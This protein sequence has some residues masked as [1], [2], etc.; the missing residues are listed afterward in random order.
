MDELATRTVPWA[1]IDVVHA[2][3]RPHDERPPLPAVGDQVWLR[4]VDWEQDPTTGHPV[5]VEL[6]TVVSVQDLEDQDDP[7]LW[8]KISDAHGLPIMAAD[9]TRLR[10]PRADPWPHLD[11][12]RP[13]RFKTDG[14]LAGYGHVIT[15]QESRMRGSA[16]WLPLN[17]RDRPERWRL[18]AETAA[19]TRP[20]L[21]PYTDYL[22]G[23]NT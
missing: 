12:R 10:I 20:P 18:P 16:G 23:D 13:D 8:Q 17:Y 14:N 6:A 19:V 21:I 11:L 1:N 7:N 15:T 2:Q 22:T 5:P 4:L 3:N 9:G